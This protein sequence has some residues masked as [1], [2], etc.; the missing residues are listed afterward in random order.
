[1][2]DVALA[3]RPG[4]FQS[5]L[6]LDGVK[7][8]EVRV[9]ATWREAV[10]VDDDDLTTFD[11]FILSVF[12]DACKDVGRAEKRPYTRC[13]FKAT[14]GGE[15]A[16]RVRSKTRDPV[17]EEGFTFTVRSVDT[18]ALTV[19]VVDARNSDARLG[20]VKMPLSFLVRSPKREFFT[21]DWKLEGDVSPNATINLS[22]KLYGIPRQQ[23]QQQQ[24]QQQHA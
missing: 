19:E 16:T 3:L 22:A 6:P 13:L 12:V 21:M 9:G 11:C 24:Q 7:R 14:Q 20:S 1:V 5:W 18:D 10:A 17:F 8:G 4:G 15:R 23:Q 2:F